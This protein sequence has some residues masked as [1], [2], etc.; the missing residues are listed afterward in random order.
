MG[1]GDVIA[2]QLIER[3]GLAQHN[4]QRT[5]KMMSIGFVFVVSFVSPEGFLHRGPDVSEHRDCCAPKKKVCRM[6]V[7]CKAPYLPVSTTSFKSCT[8]N[9]KRLYKSY[10]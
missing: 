6:F 3:R 4:V 8:K 1:A 10:L 2:Q 5:A 9:A 7:M